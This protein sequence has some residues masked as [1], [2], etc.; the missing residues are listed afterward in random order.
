MGLAAHV[1]MAY[2]NFAGFHAILLSASNLIA[3]SL[4]AAAIAMIG[5]LRDRSHAAPPPPVA[6]EEL[7][8]QEFVVLRDAVL[9][10]DRARAAA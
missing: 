10:A 2:V 7:P 8:T 5:M 6:V 9:R 3:G 1:S 4:C